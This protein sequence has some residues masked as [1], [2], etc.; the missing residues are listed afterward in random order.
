MLSMQ[1]GKFSNLG[2]IEQHPK[3]CA[4]TEISV[5]DGWSY[6]LYVDS[7]AVHETISTPLQHILH[8]SNRQSGS[9]E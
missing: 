1:I 8:R 6:I 9:R 7:H 5:V 4:Y 3:I 2:N